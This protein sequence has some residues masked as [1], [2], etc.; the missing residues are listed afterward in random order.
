MLVFKPDQL[1]LLHASVFQMSELQV[2]LSPILRFGNIEKPVTK[3]QKVFFSKSSSGLTG[4]KGSEIM[5]KSD[6]FFLLLI[7]ILLLEIF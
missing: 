4:H 5:G 7:L 1:R 3:H 2:I 6:Q